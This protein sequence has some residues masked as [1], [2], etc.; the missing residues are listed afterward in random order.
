MLQRFLEG[1]LLCAGF[2]AGGFVLAKII[3]FVA[4]QFVETND[5]GA[6][7]TR[8]L[9]A[10]RSDFERK[11]ASRIGSRRKQMAQLDYDVREAVDA[12]SRLEQEIALLRDRPD[13]LLRV[14]GKEIEG[15]EPY[16]ALVV[17]KHAASGH[18][19]IDTSWAHAQEV[20]VWAKSINDARADLEHR[21]PESMG[22]KI[23][24]LQEPSAKA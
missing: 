22:F 8:A 13:H 16:L 14:L 3:G 23:T 24:S 9:V 17:N 5:A 1:I 11:L 7:A 20:T 10:R 4:V 6:G 12:R 18:L 21:Y 15:H 2:S 19:T